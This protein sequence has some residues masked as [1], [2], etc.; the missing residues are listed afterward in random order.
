MK[1]FVK[2][3]TETRNSKQNPEQWSLKK[4]DQKVLMN[5]DDEE[6]IKTHASTQ[7]F[8]AFQEHVIIS[9]V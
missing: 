6:K 8:K 2:T 9:T 1:Q 7:E 5:A 4:S 3:G